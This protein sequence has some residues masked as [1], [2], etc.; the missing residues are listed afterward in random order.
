MAKV[1]VKNRGNALSNPYAQLP[2]KLTVDDVLASEDVAK[3]LDDDPVWV[4]GVGRGADS[5]WFM[6]HGNKALGGLLCW[7]FFRH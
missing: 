1:S 6:G 5:V 3:E 2:M 7:V 4:K